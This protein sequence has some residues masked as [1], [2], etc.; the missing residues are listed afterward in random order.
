M[1]DS[2][3]CRSGFCSSHALPCVQPPK[4]TPPPSFNPW[5]NQWMETSAMAGLLPQS[6]SCSC[7]G[8][9]VL[10][11]MFPALK[12]GQCLLCIIQQLE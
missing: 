3:P 8:P 2:P 12:V 10:W 11:S 4:A 5:T 9:G 6:D 1:P 7:S